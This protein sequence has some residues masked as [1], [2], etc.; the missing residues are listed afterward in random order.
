M[1]LNDIWR[2]FQSLLSFPRPISRKL[3]TRPQKLKLLII[4][5]TTD[6]TWHDYWWPWQYCKVSGLFNIKFLVNGA[7]YDKN[8]YRLLIGNHTLAF[9]WWHFY[10]FRLKGLWRSFQSRLS[11]PRP[12]SQ[13]LYK[14]RPLACLAELYI[15]ITVR[16]KIMSEFMLEESSA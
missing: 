4:N 15:C 8:Y 3:Y 5:H 1:T 2:S 9:D 10:T 12:V 11:F 16:F 13:K 6:F 14:I 7:W